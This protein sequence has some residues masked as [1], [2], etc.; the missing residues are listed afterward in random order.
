MTQLTEDHAKRLLR[1]YGV[2]TP[3]GRRV[4]SAV[5]AREAAA[6]FGVPV[7]VKALVPAGRR[8]LA[9]GVVRADGPDAAADAFATVTGVEIDG[10]RARS[11]YLEPWTAVAAELYLAV[12]LDPDTQRPAVLVGA[13]G[14]VDVEAG[15]RIER[16]GLRD[17]GSVPVARLRHAAA[18]AGVP[19]G[20]RTALAAVA[21]ALARAYHALDCQ[22]IEV[23]PLGRLDDGR[24]VALDA[25]IVPDEHALYRQPEIRDWLRTADPRP[26]EDRLGDETGLD[27]VPLAGRLG[28]ISGG[29]GMT[30][31]LMDLVA[32]A[33]ETPSGFLDCSANP[34]R[35][36]YGAAVDL[37][38]ADPRV[39]AI[40]ISI[41]G[42][43]TQVDRVA[44]TLVAVLAERHVDRPVTIRLMGTNVDG[45]DAVLAEAGLVNHRSIDAAVAAAV[46]SL[47]PARTEEVAR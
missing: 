10:L 22:L 30:M 38:T 43:G 33:G 18:G 35:A 12:T 8:G 26:A 44:R 45:A 1:R 9:G 2:S 37:L 17:D 28:L 5:E 29:A 32:A 25:R 46:A 16:V 15:Q 47:P 36:G 13:A 21:A 14:G 42:G 24:L 4:G 6:E 3:D 20:D 31:A 34:T 39:A 27:H 40:L 41:F 11:A 23:N 7:A 19:A